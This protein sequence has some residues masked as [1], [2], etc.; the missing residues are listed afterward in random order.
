[1]SFLLF[2]GADGINFGK[3][4]FQG[5]MSSKMLCV[6]RSDFWGGLRIGFAVADRIAL[7][8]RFDSLL[9]TGFLFLQYDRELIP[10]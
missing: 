10:T 6:S 1:M 2:F 9:L 5:I 7:S 4:V 3:S 8:V